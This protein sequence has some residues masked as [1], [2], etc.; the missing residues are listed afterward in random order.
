MY[1]LIPIV[2]GALAGVVAA[3]L[4]AG[5]ARWLLVAAVS[6]LAALMAGLASGELEESPAFLV[7]DTAQAVAA[8]VLVARLAAWARPARAARRRGD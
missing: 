8:A 7:W 6:L 4:G 1:E 2:A 5:R 3:R